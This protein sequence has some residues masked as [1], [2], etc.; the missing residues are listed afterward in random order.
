MYGQNPKDAMDDIPWHL[1][2]NIEPERGCPNC[3][4]RKWGDCVVDTSRR[5]DLFTNEEIPF[6]R[7]KSE[8][9]ICGE[10]LYWNINPDGAV[11]WRESV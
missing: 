9:M 5:R 11:K 1:P 6:W 8:C 4:C 2:M 3:D 7:A 10:P